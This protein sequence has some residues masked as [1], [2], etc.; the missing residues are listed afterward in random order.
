MTREE[1]L[2]AAVE[3][4]E[5]ICEHARRLVD[6][7][8][9]LRGWRSPWYSRLLWM[10][11]SKMDDGGEM[12]PYLASHLLSVEAGKSGREVHC[13]EI[14]AA[15]QCAYLRAVEAVRRERCRALMAAVD[16]ERFSITEIRCWPIL[17]ESPIWPDPGFC[18]F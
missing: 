10:D 6:R 9:V 1:R 2:A 4:A 11:V 13:I 17:D 14:E 18:S 16:D 8:T 3:R 5:M 7:A 15:D 12:G